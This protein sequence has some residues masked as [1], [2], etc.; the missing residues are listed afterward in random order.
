[1]LFYQ[2]DLHLSR[3]RS[4]S[5]LLGAAAD[6]SKMRNTGFPAGKRRSDRIAEGGSTNGRVCTDSNGGLDLVVAGIVLQQLQ[7]R[8]CPQAV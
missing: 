2:H 6:L 1:M 7:Q 5:D 8:V 3:Y 4:K